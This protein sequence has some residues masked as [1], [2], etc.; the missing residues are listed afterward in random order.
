MSDKDEDWEIFKGRG[1]ALNY[2]QL[3][4][5]TDIVASQGATVAGLWIGSVGAEA[6]V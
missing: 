6:E 2:N 1:Y 5:N 4:P 3:P